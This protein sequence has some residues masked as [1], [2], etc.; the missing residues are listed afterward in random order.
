MTKKGENLI[1]IE[2]YKAA[3]SEL[4]HKLATAPVLTIL[5]QL[6]G[7]VIYSDASGPGLGCV[8]M[9][10]KVVAYA[11]RHLRSHEQNYLTHDLEL[12][13]VISP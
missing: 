9:N 7:F 1:W 2:E 13:A 8:L 11:S 12:V 4:K 6:S 10:D 3:F 5:D